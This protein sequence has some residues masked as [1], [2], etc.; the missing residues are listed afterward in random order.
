MQHQNWC[1]WL[2]HDW[3][4]LWVWREQKR[5]N[6]IALCLTNEEEEVLRV[7]EHSAQEDTST[8]WCL[9][10][11]ERVVDMINW[12]ARYHDIAHDARAACLSLLSCSE[13]FF[14]VFSRLAQDNCGRK[15]FDSYVRDGILLNLFLA[16]NFCNDAWKNTRFYAGVND[17]TN[18]KTPKRRPPTKS[19]AT[20]ARGMT[21]F[22]SV[23]WTKLAV[24]IEI[25]ECR[26][27]L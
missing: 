17:P 4:K 12:G 10:S 15:W 20:K 13:L 7:Y 23:V 18:S 16:R 3:L 11:K 27:P 5:I 1:W 9:S 14:M 8:V 2:S 21:V 24:F 19:M 26:H 6:L 22:V 25:C